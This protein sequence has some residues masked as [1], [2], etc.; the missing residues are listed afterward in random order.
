MAVLFVTT[1]EQSAGQRARLAAVPRRRGIHLGQWLAGFAAVL[2]FAAVGLLFGI[3]VTRPDTV[4]ALSLL[5]FAAVAIIRWPITG[6]YITIATTV[7][8]DGYPSPYVQTVLSE[9]GFF[10]NLNLLGL[11]KSITINMFE[12]LLIVTIL[13]VVVGC[14]NRGRPLVRGPLFGPMLVFGAMVVMGEVN[15]LLTGGDFK[16]TLWEIRPLFYFVI[17]YILAINTVTDPR[18]VRAIL[19][20][21][22]LGTGL[23][24]LYGI[25]VFTQIPADLQAT[26]ETVIEHDDSLF[27][28]A[29]V[30][31]V[32]AALIWRK[33]LP[34]AFVLATVVVLPV[35]AIMMELNKRRAVFLCVALILFSMI[36][37]VWANLRSKEMR[38]RFV[39]ALA[40]AAALGGIYLA[41]FW[42]HSG[43][44]AAP[45]AAIKSY[46]QPD[47]RDYLSNLYRDEENTNVRA[48]FAGSPLIGVGFGKQMDIVVPMVDLTSKWA[49]QL[50]MPHN[51]MLWLWM[52]MGIL[53]FA[54]F[55]TT[56]A[57]ALLLI[58]A[59]MRL[60]LRRLRAV[61]GEGPAGSGPLLTRAQAQAAREAAEFMILAILL[62]GVLGALTA[63]ASA[64]QGFMSFRL[65]PYTGAIA[66]ALA[67]MWEIYSKRFAALPDAP[68]PELNTQ[69]KTAH[70]QR[71]RVRIITG[72]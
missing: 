14:F 68:L 21:T 64:D 1:D 60:G 13:R 56:I 4:I 65:M 12:V 38:Q 6:I 43:G 32:I 50:Y 71:R 48:T 31:L 26:A 55:W 34:R 15:G 37:V 8:T 7:L 67:A 52:R 41:V 61:I 58:A 62:L 11:P 9:L 2:A 18:H 29:A 5:L 23:R 17:L 54:A 53:G 72:A 39:A 20:L 44:I 57:A 35:A 16:V 28:A 27:F 63:L 47:E 22:V 19:W 49:L 3:D 70:V 25:W 66:G 51:N 42:N 30:A 33:Q 69:E 59:A 10:S 36:P 40:V 45:A 24:A 46:F